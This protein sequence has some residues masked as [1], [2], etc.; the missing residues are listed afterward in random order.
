MPHYHQQLQSH[1]LADL[2]NRAKS[3]ILTYF[4]V[5]V[6]LAFTFNLDQV[7]PSFLYL[8]TGLIILFAAL[9]IAHL[10]ILNRS[11]SPNI[12][13]LH[14]WLVITILGAALHWGCMSAWV[15][16]DDSLTVMQTA[17]LI[18][19]PAFTV[20]GASTLSISSEIRTLY[21]IFMLLPVI[22][23][24]IHDGST[25]NLMYAL[26]CSICLTYIFTSS[27]ASHNDYWSAITN[28]LVAEERAELMEQLST[29]DPLTQLK[30]RMFFD[31]EYSKEWKRCSRMSCPLSLIMIDLD[32]FKNLNDNYG[33]MFGD[34]C[35]KKTAKAINDEVARPSDCVA[36]YGGEEFIVLLP[37]TNKNGAENIAKRMLKAVSDLEFEID[38]QVINITCSIGGATTTP[39]FR[40]DRSELVKE[41]DTALYYAKEH[42]RNQYYALS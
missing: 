2:T 34:D 29:T 39:N 8:N 33:H 19:T 24:L 12:P 5:W 1:A 38:G 40:N 20:G 15:I 21:P 37:N 41:A 18:I 4:G 6:I 3:G 26:L 30:N 22:G 9:R 36:R 7:N 27:K 13:V 11:P 25:S 23:A 28:H 10:L 42:G 32:F 31:K 35:L 17:I 16:Y 14:Q